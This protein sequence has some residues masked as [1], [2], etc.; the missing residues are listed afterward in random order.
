MFRTTQHVPTRAAEI[1]TEYAATYRAKPE[2]V[3]LAAEDA[4]NVP[5]G[6]VCEAGLNKGRIKARPWRRSTKTTA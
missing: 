3:R 4:M 5:L 6:P 2:Q 1:N